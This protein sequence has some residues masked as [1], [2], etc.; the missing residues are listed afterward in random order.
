MPSLSDL[1]D[2][3]TVFVDTSTTVAT[4]DVNNAYV[5]SATIDGKTLGQTSLITLPA[6][7]TAFYAIQAFAM[8]VSVSGFTSGPTIRIGLAS[9]YTQWLALTSLNTLNTELSS[10]NLG[11]FALT[12]QT[13]FTAGD[14]IKVDVTTAAIATT[15]TFKILLIAL[16]N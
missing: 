4:S 12:K 5:I 16:Q 8:S 3:G 15:Y 7:I 9:A 2:F 1:N 6:G 10:L 13:V 14:V 11:P